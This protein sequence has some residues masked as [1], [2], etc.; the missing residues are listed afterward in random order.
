[1]ENIQVHQ[2][3]GA[4][5]LANIRHASNSTTEDVAAHGVRI[6]EYHLSDA[7][8][9]Q[10]TEEETLTITIW[11][12]YSPQPATAPRMLVSCYHEPLETKT[13]KLEGRNNANTYR[14]RR[15]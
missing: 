3:R 14:N 6:V 1:M 10:Y 12:T 4:L 7:T 2:P 13:K 5:L 11:E 8:K 9:T 15:S